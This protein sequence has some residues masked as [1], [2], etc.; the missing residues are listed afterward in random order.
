M[1]CTNCGANDEIVYW[2]PGGELCRSCYE[3]DPETKAYL[4]RMQDIQENPYTV[5]TRIETKKPKRYC[6][7]H[8]NDLG[9]KVEAVCYWYTTDGFCYHA[10]SDCGQRYGAER[11]V[12]WYGGKEPTVSD[13]IEPYDD[14]C[15]HNMYKCN[16]FTE[17]DKI[18]SY[19]IW[20]CRKCG[21]KHKRRGMN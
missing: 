9:E 5:V 4:K 17:G 1:D 19:D 20:G 3:N 11:K 15:D 2:K 6:W 8:R 7:F 14:N 18:G 12:H 10:C 21:G 13:T 16:M